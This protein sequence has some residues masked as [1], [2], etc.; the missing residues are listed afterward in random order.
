ME[1]IK[2]FPA[3]SKNGYQLNVTNILKH[4]TRNFSRQE[5]ISRKHD[6]TLF[7]YTYKDAYERV[8]KL[9][10]SLLSLANNCREQNGGEDVL[11][12]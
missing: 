12:R 3:T 10:N 4:G 8:K 11:I 7:R 9:A 1:I 5:I 2:G 6:G